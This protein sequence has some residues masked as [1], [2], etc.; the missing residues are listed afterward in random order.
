MID[1]FIHGFAISVSAVLLLTACSATGGAAGDQ[2]QVRQVTQSAHCG[3]TGP[4]VVHA[5]TSAELEALLDVGGQNISTGVIRQ[6]N[7]DQESLVIVTLGQKPTAGYSVKLDSATRENKALRLAMNVTEPA[8]G[9]MVAQVITTPCVVLAVTGEGW[10][11][12][13][14][15]GLT[16]QPILK[17]VGN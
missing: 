2:P 11:R 13:E 14:I 5:R 10:R 12:L 9:M 15:S 1:R 16:E 17:A 8:P 7:L 4:G 3:L 6:I